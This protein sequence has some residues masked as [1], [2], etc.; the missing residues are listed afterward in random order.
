MGEQWILERPIHIREQANH[1]SCIVHAAVMVPFE[2]KMMVGERVSETVFSFLSGRATP[3]PLEVEMGRQHE[4]RGHVM[5]RA[6]GQDMK[7]IV[8]SPAAPDKRLRSLSQPVIQLPN[9]LRECWSVVDHG[10]LNAGQCRAELAKP[11]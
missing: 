1:I 4:V 7:P 11:G 9:N 8:V 10:L 3:D 6:I 5:L 2:F